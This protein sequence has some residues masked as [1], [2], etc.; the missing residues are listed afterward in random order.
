MTST[1]RDRGMAVHA[2]LS[3]QRQGFGPSLLRGALAVAEPFYGLAVALRNYMYD[4]G[5]RPSHRL[6][7]P[8]ISVGNITAGGTGKT[9][10]VQW[11]ARHLRDA[12]RNPAVL[13]RG[14]HRSR[15]GISDEQ[16]V[17]RAGLPGLVIHANPDRVAG[18]REMLARHPEID[19]I[20]LDDGF[21]HRRLRRDFD[22]VLVD[23]TNPFGY[24]HLHPRGLLREPLAALR[25]AH[26]LLVTR[27]DLVDAP[28]QQQIR[29][30]LLGHNAKAPIFMA[31]HVLVG[32]RDAADSL[33]PIDSLAGRRYFAFAGIANPASLDQQLH[34]LP[35]YYA[36]HHWFPDH[37][38]YGSADLAAVRAAAGA[39]GADMLVTTAKDWA[40]VRHLAGINQATPVGRLELDIRLDPSDARSLLDSIL[41]GLR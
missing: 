40:K 6:P 17:L 2:L 23:A 4:R 33:L 35:G 26:A 1:D 24:G 14:Y 9:P 22:L 39:A 5:M 19:V 3:G 38:D 41:S 36:G 21:Q 20:L 12:S 18:G 34:N 15:Q 8:V 37:H 32:V 31:S 11:L 28:R 16:E 29:Q 30:S 13:M 10:V 25:R 7:V 27:S